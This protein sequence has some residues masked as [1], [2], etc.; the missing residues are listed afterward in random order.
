MTTSEIL[1]GARTMWE[2]VDRR[3]AASPDHPMLI[4]ADGETV[5]FGA[6][7]RPGRAGRRRP[8]RHGRDD[9]LG[10]LVAAPDPHRHR[11]ALHRAR[12]ASAP[13]RTRSSTSTAS[14]RSASRCARP[15]PRSS[16]S[17][18]PG[19]TSTSPPSP[20]APSPTRRRAPTHPRRP[21]AAFRKPTR[22][23]LP[24]PPPGTDAD[25]RPDPLDLL[26]LGIHRRPQ[27]RAAHRPDADRRRLGP[28]PRPRHASRRRRL[29]RLPLR[30]HRRPRL[31]RD[32]AL[33]RVP[34]H[35]RRGVL[36]AR[37]PAHLPPVR[38]HH[39]RR[40][41]RVLRGVPRRA[42]QGAGGPDPARAAR[43]CPAVARPS[44]PR[45]TTRCA[46]R[47]AGAASCT[48]TA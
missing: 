16:S 45:S 29:H 21:K 38:G 39:G 10:R 36:G 40:E 2:L 1:T 46:T 23:V 20:S 48:A 3:A 12:P 32:D 31:S 28:R 17:P 8:P 25:R 11:R 37:R 44:P 7:P 47:S 15:A 43:S 41:H 14:A 18:A 27:G 13:S 22:R 4:A 30:P 9:G 19:A 33:H 26:H 6:V 24:P 35:P 5:T 34:G 42:A